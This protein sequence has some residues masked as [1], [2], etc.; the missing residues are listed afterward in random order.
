MT[1]TPN[2]QTTSIS[3][4]LSGAYP[5]GLTLTNA[6]LTTALATGSAIKTGTTA[7]D[8]V[9]FRVYDVDGAAYQTF[10]TLTANNTPDVTII[11]PTGG[12][13]SIDAA[14]G[15][16]IKRAC[17]VSAR[18][19]DLTGST[20]ITEVLHEGKICKMTG[21]GSAYTQTL[22]AATG[23]GAKY[24]FVV[25][26]VNTSNHIIACAGS[27]TFYGQITT[28][29]VTDT[30]DLAQPW[31]SQGTNT[32]ITLNGTTTGGLG[33][34]DKIELVDAVSGKWLVLGFTQTS[35]TEATPFGT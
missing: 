8:T 34:G 33:I 1:S 10:M 3:G 14:T 29:S 15:A 2:T 16:E 5:D 22:P 4:D 6:V 13:L 20:S 24:T 7:A 19:V 21:T 11:T 17:D 23:G 12:S 32:K 18:V 28:C 27:D 30:P 35:G 9:L 25:G 26:A 31:P